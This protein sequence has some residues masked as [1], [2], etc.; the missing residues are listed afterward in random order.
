MH[1]HIIC[2]IFNHLL[3]SSLSANKLSEGREVDGLLMVLNNTV[4][5]KV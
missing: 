4:L 5:W 1:E 3:T 2:T